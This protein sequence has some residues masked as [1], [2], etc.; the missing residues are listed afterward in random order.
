MSEKHDETIEKAR[1]EFLS[2]AGR[3]ALTTPPAMAILMSTTGRG[4]TK[5]GSFAKPHDDNGHGNDPG[6][7]DPSNPGKKK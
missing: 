3:L 7:F 2:K 5:A 4:Y 6:K 1:R